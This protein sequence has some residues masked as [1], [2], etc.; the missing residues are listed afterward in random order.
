MFL[1]QVDD[2]RRILWVRSEDGMPLPQL[3]KVKFFCEK[4]TD[5]IINRWTGSGE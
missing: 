2:W 3:N 4:G 1:A 5:M